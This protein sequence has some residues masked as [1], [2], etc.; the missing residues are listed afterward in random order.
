[1]IGQLQWLFSATRSSIE[2]LQLLDWSITFE[3]SFTPA[4]ESLLP[5]F[6]PRNGIVD[7]IE[8][9]NFLMYNTTILSDDR[10][11]VA[12]GDGVVYFTQ[13]HSGPLLIDGPSTEWESVTKVLMTE[14]KV[15]K[16]V[17]AV[18]DGRP[19]NQAYSS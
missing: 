6:K 19:I 4:S 1:M 5:L 10:V 16:I 13:H 17:F 7:Y 2:L 14:G 3:C 9:H 12:T 18:T 11:D 8:R 15:Y